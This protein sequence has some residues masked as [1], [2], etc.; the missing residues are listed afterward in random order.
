MWPGSKPSLLAANNRTGCVPS[1]MM[2][3]AGN[4]QAEARRIPGMASASTV[5]PDWAPAPRRIR[6]EATDSWGDKVAVDRFAGK[7]SHF[8]R[9]RGRITGRGR[10]S[11]GHRG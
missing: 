9:G 5:D 2:I 11:G 3:R 6:E 4:L 1:K 10:G 8:V 7:G